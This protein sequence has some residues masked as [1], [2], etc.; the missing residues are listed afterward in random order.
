MKIKNWTVCVQGRGKRRD[1]VEKAKTFNIWPY[2]RRHIKLFLSK[3]WCVVPLVPLTPNL[4]VRQSSVDNVTSRLLYAGTNQI[5]C[6]MGLSSSLDI[7]RKEANL[8]SWGESN[9]GP[10]NLQHSR[11]AD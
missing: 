3:P 4:G 10:F 1:V 7:I 2:P 9:P 11:C 6:W 5:R 8:L